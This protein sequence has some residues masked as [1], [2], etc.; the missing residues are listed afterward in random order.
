MSHDHCNH[1][2]RRLGISALHFLGSPPTIRCI[3]SMHQRNTGVTNAPLDEVAISTQQAAV[4]LDREGTL[5]VGSL[6][7]L[8]LSTALCPMDAGI[9]ATLR[10]ELRVDN[11]HHSLGVE[12]REQLQS[13][14]RHIL[15]YRFSRVTELKS[16]LW[17]VVREGTGTT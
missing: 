7:A 10:A 14:S 15:N 9:A 13:V 1:H 11:V 5:P 6:H 12:R 8:P 4:A 17:L 2:R 16:F 3:Y